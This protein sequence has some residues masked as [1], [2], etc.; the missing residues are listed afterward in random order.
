MKKYA[1]LLIAVLFIVGV[2]QKSQ[3][4][5]KQASAP[6]NISGVLNQ[7]QSDLY[8]GFINPDKLTMHHSFSMSYGGFTGGNGMML[9]TYMNTIDYQFTDKLFL[10]TNL[11]IM[12]SPYNTFSKDFILNK[13][14][15]FGSAELTYKLNDN[16]RIQLGIQRSPFMYYN[17]Y[18]GGNQA[19]PFR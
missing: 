5:F 7:G 2:P 13:P 1:A 19:Y 10:R 6:P 4:Q 9:S 16:T 12:S 18:Y 17:P 3:A 11:G 15:F 8:L 14:Q